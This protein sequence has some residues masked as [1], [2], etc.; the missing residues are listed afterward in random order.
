MVAKNTIEKLKEPTE[1]LSELRDT[2]REAVEKDWTG[3]DP[4]WAKFCYEDCAPGITK[5]LARERSNDPKVSTHTLNFMSK[6]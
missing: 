4:V 2:L 6:N 1:A 5:L 3:T